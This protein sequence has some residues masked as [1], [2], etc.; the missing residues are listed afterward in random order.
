MSYTSLVDM[1]LAYLCI[2]VAVVLLSRCRD[3]AQSLCDHA[4]LLS[5]VLVQIFNC[6][7]SMDPSFFKYC[8]VGITTMGKKFNVPYINLLSYLAQLIYAAAVSSTLPLKCATFFDTHIDRIVGFAEAL[9]FCIE[10]V[11]LFLS[12]A[13]VILFIALVN[14]L[15]SFKA[16]FSTYLCA[17]CRFRVLVVE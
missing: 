16:F 8:L 6:L 4:A 15:T 13:F 12:L 2:I 5:A 10:L 9:V 1:F 3:L 17:L 7:S 11:L 14:P